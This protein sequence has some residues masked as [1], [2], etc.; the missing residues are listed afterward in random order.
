MEKLIKTVFII[1]LLLGVLNFT[2]AEGKTAADFYKENRVTLMVPFSAGGGTD[3]EARLWAAFWAN[4]TGGSIIVKNLPGGGGIKAVN[5]VYAAKPDGLT[6]G[7]L[8]LSTLSLNHIFKEPGVKYDIGKF[9]YLGWIGR[10][11][12]VAALSSRSS[13]TTLEDLK[14][15]KPK[16]LKAAAAGRTMEISAAMTWHLLDLNKCVVV[17]GFAGGP[18]RALAVG[19]GEADMMTTDAPDLRQWHGQ[20]YTKSPFI[21]LSSERTDLWPKTP[22]VSEAIDMTPKKTRLWEIYSSLSPSRP[23]FLPPG[24]PN[25]RIEFLRDAFVKIV[26]YKGYRKTVKKAYGIAQPRHKTGEEVVKIVTKLAAKSE[27][28]LAEFVK[29]LDSYVKK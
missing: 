10:Y 17:S 22:A 19:R 15:A 25:D 29:T 24:V 20:G 9:N 12:L 5:A 11:D 6:M 1:T 23:I 7:I 14:K 26:T 18:E 4:I 28:E 2:F 27:S 3:V 16:G 13:Y 8:S 21:Y